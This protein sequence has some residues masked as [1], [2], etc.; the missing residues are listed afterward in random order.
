MSEI[1][2]NVIKKIMEVLKNNEVH[3][4]LNFNS[5]KIEEKLGEGDQGPVFKVK[6][7]IGIDFALKLYPPEKIKY[8]NIKTGKEIDIPTEIRIL[9]SLRHK[10]I[11]KIFSGGLAIWDENNQSWKIYY[12]FSI[13]PSDPLNTVYFYI[14]EYI[15]GSDLSSLFKIS[16]ELSKCED[17]EEYSIYV[18]FD[19]FC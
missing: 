3:N 15:E 14:M 19:K 11:V 7:M 12:D 17:N 8:R 6:S 13:I 5:Y 9:I 18:K 2:L 10:N 1:K 4:I 16:K